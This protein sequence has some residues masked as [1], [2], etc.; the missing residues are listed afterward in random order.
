[1]VADPHRVSGLILLSLIF[2]LGLLPPETRGE[3]MA[4]SAALVTLLVVL[5]WKRVAPGAGHVILVLLLVLAWPLMIF[6]AA[7][8]AAV[9][10][11]AFAV[12]AVTL[13]VHAGVLSESLGRKPV[14]PWTLS[15][16]GGV[17][18]LY[19]LAQWF[20]LLDARAERV[21]TAPGVPDRDL[22]LIRLEQGRAFEPETG[23]ALRAR[24]LGI[25]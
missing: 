18:G 16:A 17:V 21:A 19:A 23:R 14:L 22:V 4:G 24:L 2:V 25:C 20:W 3:S 5:S 10:P 9:L 13:G 15:V 12:L 1:M 11:I 6:S 8:G 7:P